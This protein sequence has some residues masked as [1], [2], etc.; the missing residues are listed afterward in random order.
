MTNLVLLL[1]HDLRVVLMARHQD[2]EAQLIADGQALPVGSTDD[3]AHL[4]Q[5]MNEML[6]ELSMDASCRCVPSS[7]VLLKEMTTE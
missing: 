3:F 6:D 4:I 2:D 5:L 7:Q 1:G